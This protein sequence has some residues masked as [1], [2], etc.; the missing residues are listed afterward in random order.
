MSD[1]L[2]T[3]RNLFTLSICI[4]DY[5]V[6][7][8]FHSYSKF[9]LFVSVDATLRGYMCNQSGEFANLTSRQN[10]VVRELPA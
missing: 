1:L 7:C 9:K 6:K 3:H 10:Q 2:Y 8:I 4:M 5:Y